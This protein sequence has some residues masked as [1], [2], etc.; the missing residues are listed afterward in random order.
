MGARKATTRMV[1]P[2][3]AEQYLPEE[4][5]TPVAG[6]LRPNSTMARSKHPPP[7]PDPRFAGPS[8]YAPGEAWRCAP[9]HRS[10]RYDLHRAPYAH[11]DFTSNAPSKDLFSA[12]LAQQI[13]AKALQSIS[14]AMIAQR[15]EFMQSAG[16]AAPA[17]VRKRRP[18]PQEGK[19]VVKTLDTP[20]ALRKTIG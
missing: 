7:L 18:C 16:K 11:P 19:H 17:R 12:S 6:C 9:W 14:M 15:H 8:G 3:R 1:R 2:R 20:L 5:A 4:D 10:P 13:P